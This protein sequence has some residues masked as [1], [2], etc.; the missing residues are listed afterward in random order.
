MG[1]SARDVK[2]SSVWEF[3]NL[4]SGFNTFHG[5]SDEGETSAPSLEEFEAAQARFA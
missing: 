1:L 5:G 2:E 3:I 4:K